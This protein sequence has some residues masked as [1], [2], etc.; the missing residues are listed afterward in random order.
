MKMR[1]N[2]LC[3]LLPALGMGNVVGFIFGV[4]LLYDTNPT[5]VIIGKLLVGLILI[6]TISLLALLVMSSRNEH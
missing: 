6:T 1:F 2:E 4:F 3:E 5:M